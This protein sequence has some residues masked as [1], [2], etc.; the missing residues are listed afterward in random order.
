MCGIFGYI[1]KKDSLEV[2][3]TGLEQLE[4]RGYDST[5]IAGILEGKIE[6]CKK[7][8]KLANLRK[9][10]HLK[11]LD[12]AIGHT[13]WATHGKVSDA[14]AHPHLDHKNELA[15]V[16]NGIIE[17][18]LKL[19]EFLEK[20]NVEFKSETDSEVLTQLISF[21]YKGDLF[22]AVERALQD[23]EGIYAI[24]VIHLEHPNLIVVAAHECPIAIGIDDQFTESFIS[25]D[26]NSFGQ[27]SLN[28]IYLK[29]S[30]IAKVERGNIQ[31]F[32][33]SGKV[34]K[35]SEKIVIECPRPTKGNFEHFLLKEIFEQPNTILK[36]IHG[37]FSEET[38]AVHLENFSVPSHFNRVWMIGCGT[39]A[40]A[41]QI[42]CKM[43][44][45]YAKIPAD[46]QIASEAKLRTGILDQNTFVVALSQSGETADT[47]SALRNIKNAKTLGICNVS[48]STLTREV[49]SCLFLKA[50]PEISVCSSKAFT[51]QLAV[52]SLLSIE[53]AKTKGLSKESSNNFF[54][55]LKKIPYQVQ[56]VLDQAPMIEQLAKKYSKYDD[57]F[58]M[59]RHYMYD[60]A[61]EA[62][63]K[64]KEISYVNANAYPA[65][66]LKHGAIALLCDSFP[67]VAFC[68]NK[69]TEDKIISNLT[70]VK[71]RG[72]PLLAIA[73]QDMLSVTKIADDVIF[74]PPTIDSLS[75]FLST[76][77]SQL[78]AYYI[79]KERGCDIDQP[80]NL[81]KS[82][83]VE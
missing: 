72:A 75:P 42:G 7:A 23:V 38:G 35:T 3:L 30:E 10:L 46:C 20:Q 55:A 62:A 36:A 5:G 79:A 52:L 24:A 73:P 26:P 27:S 12:L 49:D 76:V 68:A 71:A 18:F 81:A 16:H 56:L 43:V 4:Y 34:E 45:E 51:S 53:L 33:R 14:N 78:L 31:I 15:L 22:K 60:T 32:N 48:H 9:A 69:Q 21:Y 17:N 13:R 8:G 65:G 64:L 67:V 28:V 82:V 41:G 2:C 19:K 74:V 59:G 39:S 50:G 66:E 83:T 57:F 1:G 25:S 61:L 47:I 29:N 6:S 54:N 44:E 58:F 70:E 37:R 11:K 77:A 40:H 80:R 63:L